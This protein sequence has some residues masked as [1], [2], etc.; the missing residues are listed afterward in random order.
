MIKEPTK[1]GEP[2]EYVEALRYNEGKTR[3]DLI[4]WEWEKWLADSLGAGAKKYADHN[5]KKGFK[6]S[7]PLAATRRHICD[8]QMGD[9][10]NEENNCHPL[11]SAATNLLMLAYLEQHGLGKD[12][13]R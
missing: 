2:R 1:F 10:W 4:P 11:V 6:Y 3:Y 9:N 7:V 13:V 5:W 8:W 12:D